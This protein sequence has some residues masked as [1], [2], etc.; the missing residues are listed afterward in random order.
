MNN[1]IGLDIGGTKIAGAMFDAEG[2]DLA[3]PVRNGVLSASLTQACPLNPGRRPPH[4]A[5]HSPQKRLLRSSPRWFQARK[6]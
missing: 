3:P 2:R 4:Q 5:P 6:S 1:S